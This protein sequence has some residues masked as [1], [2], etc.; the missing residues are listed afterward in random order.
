MEYAI[1][2]WLRHLEAGLRSSASEHTVLHK[3]LAESLGVLIEQHWYNP[4]VDINEVSSRTR[5]ILE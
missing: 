3:D 4:S 2:Y 1:L 5:E